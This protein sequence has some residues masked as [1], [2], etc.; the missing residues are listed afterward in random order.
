M[1][2]EKKFYSQ[3]AIFGLIAAFLSMANHISPLETINLNLDFIL[4]RIIARVGVPFF[5]MKTGFFLYKNDFKTFK[6]SI[7]K[8]FKI[9]IIATIIYIPI[10]IYNH[11]FIENS[12]LTIIKDFL[13]NGLFYHLWYFPNVIIGI[14]LVYFLNKKLKFK[15]TFIISII[16]Y[17]IALFGDSYYYL[18]NKTI[19]NYFYDFIFLFFNYTKN[20]FL[21]VPIFLVLGGY[22]AKHEDKK[23]SII[24]IFILLIPMIIEGLIL[25]HFNL[26]RHDSM[27]IFLPP[28]MYF[29][30]NYLKDFHK[31]LK[32]NYQKVTLIIY[33]I[34]PFFIVVY[35]FIF[36]LFNKKELLINNNL[37]LYILVSISSLI[38]GII[39]TK[40]IKKKN[41]K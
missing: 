16:L 1:I 30:F 40:L 11:Y 29:L 7:I 24:Y 3:L 20:G 10:L 19:I 14:I 27:Y 39:I 34:H 4:T 13:F 17:I 33:I 26:Q 2:E 8:L 41:N 15:T 37:L 31:N 36:G 38:L 6:K 9:Y 18:I 28:L 21:Y 25:K 12:I 22:I 32:F 5:I 35:R 23:T